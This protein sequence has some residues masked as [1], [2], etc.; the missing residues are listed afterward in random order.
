MFHPL[1]VFAL[2]I[3]E[4]LEARKDSTTGILTVTFLI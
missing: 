3:D 4:A 1:I 2:V